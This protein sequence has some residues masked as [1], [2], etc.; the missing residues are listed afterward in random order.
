MV[1]RCEREE[2]L[3]IQRDDIAKIDLQYVNEFREAEKST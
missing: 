1:R 3:G 2:S